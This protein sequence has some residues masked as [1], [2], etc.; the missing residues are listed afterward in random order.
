MGKASRLKAERA[1]DRKG[2]LVSV[3]QRGTPEEELSA[4]TSVVGELFGIEAD[5]AAAAG[6]LVAI[7]D[8]LGHALRPRPVAAIIR[9]TK[10]NTLLAMG[11]KA[12]KKFSPEQIAGMENHRPGGRDTGH[13][14]VTSDEHKLLLDPNMRQLGNVGVDAPS[15]LIRVRSTEPESGEWQFRHEG[16][17]IL[18]FVD[19][20]N[21]ALLPHYENAHRESR[22]Y[23]QAIAEGIRAG[24][25]PIEIAA[26]MKKS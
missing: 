1:A 9:E 21:R 15:I 26:R 13:L 6:L 23:A 24:V 4:A 5:C 19:D 10:S 16:L 14:V 25:D 11:P 22:V 12:T 3:G 18:Y 2:R 20:E 17:E 7:G 8:E